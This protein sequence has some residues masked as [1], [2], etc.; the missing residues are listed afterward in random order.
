VFGE[1]ERFEKWLE[2]P[3]RAFG[4]ARPLELLNTLSGIAE[5]KTVIGRFEHGVY[6]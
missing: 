2:R 1:K 4:D 5:V 6:S 3:N